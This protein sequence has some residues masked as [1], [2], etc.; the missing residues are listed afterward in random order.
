VA[1]YAPAKARDFT[2]PPDDEANLRFVPTAKY[3]SNPAR[4]DPTMAEALGM[5]LYP[6]MGMRW[7]GGTVS[8]C[9]WP[10]EKR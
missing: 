6:A 4:S 7:S 3:R 2:A 1:F 10:L 8:F 9:N 5:A